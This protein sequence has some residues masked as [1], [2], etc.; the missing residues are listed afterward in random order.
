MVLFLASP[1]VW[2]CD[3]NIKSRCNITLIKIIFLMINYSSIY[4]LSTETKFHLD[5]VLCNHPHLNYCISNKFKKWDFKGWHL[6][7][8]FIVKMILIYFLLSSQDGLQN[9]VYIQMRFKLLHHGRCLS[10]VN[11]M[12]LLWFCGKTIV[13]MPLSFCACC[14][15]VTRKLSHWTKSMSCFFASNKNMN[16]NTKKTSVMFYFFSHKRLG[17]VLDFLFTYN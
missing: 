2:I 16:L 9:I 8:L 10:V 15:F 11:S 5:K 13:I 12:C 6:F 3:I 17:S 4:F 7:P 1:N 14:G